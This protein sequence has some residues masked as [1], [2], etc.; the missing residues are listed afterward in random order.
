MSCSR[1]P[2]KSWRIIKGIRE[3]WR[4][5]TKQAAERAIN[6]LYE[7]RMLEARDNMDGTITLVLNE[8]GKKKALTFKAGVM[9]INCAGP[10][11]G[12]WRVVIFDIPEDERDARDAL[13]ER[14]EYMGFFVLQRSVFA[15]PF[16]CRDEVEFLIE[17]YGIREY[18]RF[19]IVQYID[20]EAHLKKFFKLN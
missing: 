4:E 2:Q 7:S 17:L 3:S 16:D 6:A 12:K 10:W 13:R 15:H 20:N 9:K 14:L 18:V 5:I 8:K 11:D 19:M 1:S